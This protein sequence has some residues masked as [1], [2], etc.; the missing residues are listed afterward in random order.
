MEQVVFLRKNGGFTLLEVLVAVAILSFGI[1]YVFHT[2]FSAA[3][4]LK[5]MDNRI[6]ASF[7]LEKNTWNTKKMFFQ[8]D[9]MYNY[10]DRKLVGEDPAVDAVVSLKRVSGYSG[11]FEVK[12]KAYWTEGRRN[13]TFDK[14]VYIRN[15]FIQNEGK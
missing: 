10:T 3:S 9:S 8:S 14:V 13:I 6:S 7:L 11:V 5:H 12:A 15:Q 1:V 2:F 4:A